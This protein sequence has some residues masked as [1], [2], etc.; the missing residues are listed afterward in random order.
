M[1]VSRVSEAAK[2]I[3]EANGGSV[4]KVHYNKAG[5]GHAHLT[6]SFPEFELR[7]GSCALETQPRFLS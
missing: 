5:P 2:E 1:E 3:I 7:A 4:T 6:P